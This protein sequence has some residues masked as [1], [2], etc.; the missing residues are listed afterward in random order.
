M[1]RR[2]SKSRRCGGC[3]YGRTGMSD[4]HKYCSLCG[5]TDKTKVKED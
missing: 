5:W 4:G 1:A 3:G 2:D